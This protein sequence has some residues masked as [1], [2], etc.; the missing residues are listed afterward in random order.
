MSIIKWLRGDDRKTPDRVS[1]AAKSAHAG[2]LCEFVGSLVRVNGRD[3]TGHYSR[4]PNGR[5]I[6]AWRDANDA[7][8]HGGARHA[9]HG[10]YL[11]IEG[12]TVIADG[13]AERPN[14]GKV[15]DNGTFVINDWLFSSVSLGGAFL[16]FS[17]CSTGV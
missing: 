5:Y 7:G 2:T 3:F 6:I 15:A 12:E 14:D 11:L 17:K 4:S 16:A 1:G 10:R 8:T 9:G 13:R